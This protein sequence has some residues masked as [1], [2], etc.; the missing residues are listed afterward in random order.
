MKKNI[1]MAA[2]IAVLAFGLFS[3]NKDEKTA[4]Q[5]LTIEKGWQL[6]EGSIDPAYQFADGSQTSNLM[7]YLYA[8]EQDDQIFFKENGSETIKTGVLCD[9]GLQGAEVAAL[10]H[11]DDP[12]NATVLYMQLPFFYNADF[13]SYDEELENCTI[14]TLNDE[15]LKMKYTFQLAADERYTFTMTYLPS[16]K[17]SK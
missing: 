5:Y 10:W 16:N 14:M 15:M 8:C 11:F 9:E 3:C 2:F 4:T 13:T 6:S 1:L 7:D 17:V 12:E